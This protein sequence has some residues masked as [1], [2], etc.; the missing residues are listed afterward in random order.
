MAVTVSQFPGVYNDAYGP[1]AIT[2][3]GLNTVANATKYVLQI[4]DYNN[5]AAGPVA[6]IRQTENNAGDAIFDVQ[7]ILQNFTAQSPIDTELLG[8]PNQDPMQDCEAEGFK[9]I[10]GFGHEIGG[11]ATVQS[12]TTQPT[13]F[14]G[15]KPRY[16]E[17][18]DFAAYRANMQGDDASPAC[19]EPTGPSR[20]NIMTDWDN[21]KVTPTS[22]PDGPT[23]GIQGNRFYQRDLLR[24]DNLTLTYFSA[25]ERGQD[26]MADALGI[27]AFRYHVYNGNTLLDTV[28]V[29]NIIRNGGGPN[30]DIAD[31]SAVDYPHD[32]I[33]IAAGPSNLASLKYYND[34]AG[35]L[36]TYNLPLNATHY[37]ITTHALTPPTCESDQL[38]E[39]SMHKPY[40]VDIVAADC[41]DYEPIQVS[42]TNSFG[43]RDY[44]TF[45]KKHVYST[46]T[47]RNEFLKDNVNYYSGTSW[48]MD[49]AERGFTNYS[50]KIQEMYEASTGYLTDKEAVYMQHLYR[51]PDSRAMLPDVEPYIDSQSGEEIYKFEP[52]NLASNTYTQK[53]YKK[54][55]LFQYTIKFKMAN[56]I[57]SQRG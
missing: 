41:L 35:S 44:W 55:K 34:S 1:N 16:E 11:T 4:T 57:K 38:C 5:V 49:P 37:Y 18:R 51:S 39:Q 10:I 25:I 24:T 45:K 36:Q 23:Q 22:V 40:R 29:P 6:D 47:T 50:Q 3:T 20:A 21:I 28:T 56:N 9:Y 8:K 42:W 53:T 26:L 14:G 32:T 7:N 52:I 17:T 13:V 12:Y 27:E 54:D 19:T 31:G 30:T 15:V 46:Q 48:S 43:Y 33:T 2:L